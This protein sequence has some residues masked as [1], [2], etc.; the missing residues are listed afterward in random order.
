[1]NIPTEY[2][3]LSPAETAKALGVT[4]EAI[5]QQRRRD[6]GFCAYC[7]TPALEGM[8]LCEVH[9]TQRIRSGR[10]RAGSNPWKLG[11]PGRPPRKV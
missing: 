2:L 8:T 3:A 6:K 5:K 4:V 10:A 9:R 11:G 1:M 7:D